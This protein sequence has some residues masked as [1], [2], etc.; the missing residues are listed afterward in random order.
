MLSNQKFQWLKF[1]PHLHST[2][3][4]LD[5]TFVKLFRS[6]KMMTWLEES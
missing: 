3:Q 2:K 6:H 4:K 1:L 5:E